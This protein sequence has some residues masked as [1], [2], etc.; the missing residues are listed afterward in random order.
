[1]K[2]TTNNLETSLRTYLESNNDLICS[3]TSGEDWSELYDL[4][5]RDLSEFNR[6]ELE[7]SFNQL[8]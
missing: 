7:L 4:L 5:E 3:L 1:M 2:T 6:D 8:F